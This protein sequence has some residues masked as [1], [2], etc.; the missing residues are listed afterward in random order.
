V[1]F[2]GGGPRAVRV[3][4]HPEAFELAEWLARGGQ[5]GFE[6]TLTVV[7]APVASAVHATVTL[8]FAGEVAMGSVDKLYRDWFSPLTFARLVGRPPDVVEVLE[9]NRTHVHIRAVGDSL[10]GTSV[11]DG[12]GRGGALGAVEVANVMLGLP[13]E[14]GLMFAGRSQ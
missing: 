10:I 4:D 7:S 12:L 6:L 5:P 13:S 14:A 1:A 11:T 9:S 2:H 3:G 8:G